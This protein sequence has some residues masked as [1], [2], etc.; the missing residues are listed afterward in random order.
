MMTQRI[1]TQTGTA[2]LISLVILVVMT[3]LGISAM[4]NTVLETKMATNEQQRQIA[5]QAAE[6]A[7]RDAEAWL[8]NTIK[9]KNDL[10]TTFIFNPAEFAS[11]TAT[12]ADGSA[13]YNSFKDRLPA[14][15]TN[16]KA[17]N[18][19]NSIKADTVQLTNV[20]GHDPRYVIE[21]VGQVGRPPAEMGS[22]AARDTRFHAFKIT[23]LGYGADST[24]TYLLSSTVFLCLGGIC[25]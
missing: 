5:Y 1:N 23:A 16:T 8:Q 12:T 11:T 14:Q 25:G 7:L 21:Y 2:L 3:I 13:F 20:L 22:L 6:K 15:L 9:S 24:A 17:W 18:D 10:E 4:S 19:K